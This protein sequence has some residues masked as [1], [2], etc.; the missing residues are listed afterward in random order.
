MSLGL[1][2]LIL[3]LIGFAIFSRG[4]RIV[5]L[6]LIASDAGPPLT[7]DHAMRHIHGGPAAAVLVA[8][9]G[10]VASFAIVVAARGKRAMPKTHASVSPLENFAARMPRLAATSHR[11]NGNEAACCCCATH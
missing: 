9:A 11:D 1:A 4:F 8:S 10:T 5:V 3:G 6:T 2:I 7:Q